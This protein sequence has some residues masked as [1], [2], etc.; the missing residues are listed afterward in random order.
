[1]RFGKGTVISDA[2][3]V[4]CCLEIFLREATTKILDKI[5]SVWSKWFFARYNKYEPEE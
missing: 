3:F 4:R 5:K 1:L 2:K